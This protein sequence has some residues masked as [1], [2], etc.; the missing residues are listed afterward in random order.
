MIKKGGGNQDR[1]LRIQDLGGAKK[2]G[3]F[4]IKDSGMIEDR[5][6]RIEEKNLGYGGR[7]QD[8]GGLVERIR[9]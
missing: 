7:I 1:G 5:E 6:W 2:K 9:L 8:S 3:G 4:R